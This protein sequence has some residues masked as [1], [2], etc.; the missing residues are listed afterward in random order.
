M[1]IETNEQTL[2]YSVDQVAKTMQISRNLAYRLCREGKI[3]CLHLGQKRMLCPARAID[4]L[5]ET[6]NIDTN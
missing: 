3:P 4:K 6:G 1:T 2:V 5:L